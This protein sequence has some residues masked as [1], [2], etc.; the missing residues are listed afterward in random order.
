MAGMILR[1]LKSEKTPLI[2]TNRAT[3]VWRGRTAPRLVGDFSG[4]DDGIPIKMEKSASGLWTHQLNLP[5]DAYIEYGFIYDQETQVDPLNPRR[6]SNGVGGYNSYFGMSEYK[7]TDLTRK[8]RQVVHGRITHYC[9]PTEN[10]ISGST[11]RIYLYQP[12]VTEPVPLVVVWDGQEY[13]KRVRLNYILDN[14]FAQGRIRPIG[15]AFVSNNDQRSRT[16]EYACNDATLFFLLT[17][18]IPL[19]KRELNLLDIRKNPGEYGIM[20]SSMGGLMALYTGA[21]QP[22]IFGK[23]FSQSGAF[24][25]GG[26]DMGVFT[27]LGCQKIYPMKIWMDVGIYDIPGLLESNRRMSNLLLQRG[28]S[29]TYR[30]YNAGHNY[31][32]WRDDIW[33]GLE[34]LYGVDT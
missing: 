26:F 31:P 9:L 12:P 34:M 24:A 6:T 25:F 14:L 11:R 20:G 5:P 13:L 1:R 19:A 27:L 3:F 10:L 7:P 15:L 30:E 29:Y 4:W 17:K 23:V 18:V 33:R 21:R 16:G 28:Y 32:A 2:D 8:L 22:E